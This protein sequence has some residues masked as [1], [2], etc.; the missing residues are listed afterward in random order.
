M[1][2]ADKDGII[3]LRGALWVHRLLTQGDDHGL[4]LHGIQRGD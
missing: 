3:V 1:V 4:H 2:G